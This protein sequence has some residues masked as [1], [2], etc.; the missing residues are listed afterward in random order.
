ME[1]FAVID[2]EGAID[3]VPISEIVPRGEQEL[4]WRKEILAASRAG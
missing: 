2:F 3:G 4:A 1:D